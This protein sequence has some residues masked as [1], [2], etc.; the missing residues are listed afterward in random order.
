MWALI[1]GHYL[2]VSGN[3]KDNGLGKMKGPYSKIVG[4]QEEQSVHTRKENA[5][6]CQY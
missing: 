5:R 6:L 3:L 2:Q 4:C 1:K